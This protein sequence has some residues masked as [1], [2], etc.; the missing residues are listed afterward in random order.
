MRQDRF[1]FG[2]VAGSLLLVAAALIFARLAPPP[3]SIP[4]D[5]PEGVAY[6]YLLALQRDDQRKAYSYLSARGQA[7]ANPAALLPA[8]NYARLKDTR[9]RVDDVTVDGNSARLRVTQFTF[10][11]GGLFG[12]R[13]ERTDQTVVTLVRENGAWKIDNFF[14]P[15]WN[16]GWD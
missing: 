10:M 3:T 13:S 11:N 16:I 2:I 1:L 14:Y 4:D 8:Y 12:G 15:F 7:R 9:M 6:N 5:T